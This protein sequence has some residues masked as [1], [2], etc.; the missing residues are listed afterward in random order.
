VV[1]ECLAAVGARAGLDAANGARILHQTDEASGKRVTVSVYPEAVAL[2][3]KG[4]R[5]QLNKALAYLIW[6][7]IRK[8]PGEEAKVSIS[9]GQPHGAEESVQLLVSSRTAQVR[10]E[11]L[12][13]IFDPL[14]VVQESLIDVG[15]YVSQRI[16][17]A[18]GGRLQARQGRHE[19]AFL[20]SLPLTL[21]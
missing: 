13:Q 20:A 7:L 18:Q 14:K 4:D 16:I 10:A 11:E 6:Y 3:V 2:K 21:A 8:S 15:P 19:V 5:V 9:V 17:E 12:Q 1:E